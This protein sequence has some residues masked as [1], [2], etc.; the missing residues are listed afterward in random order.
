MAIFQLTRMAAMQLPM[1]NLD[2][3]RMRIRRY[4]GEKCCSEMGLR[5][6]KIDK[7]SMHPIFEWEESWIE[8]FWVISGKLHYIWGIILVW[9]ATSMPWGHHF[10]WDPSYWWIL[11]QDGAVF[12]GRRHSFLK[13]ERNDPVSERNAHPF[14]WIIRRLTGSGIWS[15]E[16]RFSG[17]VRRGLCTLRQH[18]DRSCLFVSLLACLLVCPTL[19]V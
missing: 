7:I 1:N 3:D 5:G 9:G 4:G 10:M 17:K 19:Q 12:F 13:K 14:S 8:Q 11:V 15:S 2:V 18:R 6:S 16:R